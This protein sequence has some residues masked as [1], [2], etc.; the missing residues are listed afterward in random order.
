MQNHEKLMVIII[1]II[2]IIINNYQIHMNLVSYEFKLR[3]ENALIPLPRYTY[4]VH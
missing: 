3:S 4:V 1:I 2:N